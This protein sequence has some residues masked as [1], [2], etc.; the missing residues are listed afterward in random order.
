MN[1]QIIKSNIKE[2]REELEKIENEID[3]SEP[4]EETELMLM[5]EHAYHHLNFAWNIRN[6]STD[7]YTIMSDEDFNRWGKFPT[8]IDLAEIKSED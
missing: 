7:R 4:L 5:M 2:A 8:D 6:V 3:S 1:W